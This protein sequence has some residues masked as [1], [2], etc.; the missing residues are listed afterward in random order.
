MFKGTKRVQSQHQFWV[1]VRHW[2]ADDNADNWNGVC[3]NGGT[4]WDHW[5]QFLFLKKNTRNEYECCYNYLKIDI[6]I[7]NNST[8]FFF[9][10]PL[11]HTLSDFLALFCHKKINERCCSKNT[12]RK[13]QDFFSPSHPRFAYVYDVSFW[14]AKL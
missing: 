4:K 12:L 10:P 2:N 6:S 13:T 9:S 5:W 1:L 7:W 3:K 8:Q 11:P 14:P